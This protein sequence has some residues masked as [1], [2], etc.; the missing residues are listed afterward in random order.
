VSTLFALIC[1]GS[2]VAFFIYWWKQRKVRLNV[3]DSYETD[4]AYLKVST[5]KQQAGMV[6]LITFILSSVFRG[7]QPIDML[8]NLFLSV[9]V[10]TFFMFL[11]YWRKKVSVRRDAGENYQDNEHYLHISKIKRI[12]GAICIVAFI[13]GSV[14]PDSP[15]EQIK[16]AET[17]AKYEQKEMEKQKDLDDVRAIFEAEYGQVDLHNLGGKTETKIDKIYFKGK[18]IYV[19]AVTVLKSNNPKGYRSEDMHDIYV[20]EKKNGQWVQTAVNP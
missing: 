16:K 1:L 11:Y 18:K 20:Y 5:R 19:D 13:L 7:L 4:E 10:V 3:G 14:T 15:D 2:F 12:I 8:K 6:F 9:W 17:K